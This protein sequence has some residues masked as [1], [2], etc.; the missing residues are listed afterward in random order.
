MSKPIDQDRELFEAH[1]TKRGLPITKA[2]EAYMFGNGRRVAAGEYILEPTAEAWVA[3]QA[4]ASVQPASVAAQEVQRWHIGWGGMESS[5]NGE[6]VNWED[7]AALVTML[8]AA[9]Q[10]V[11]GEQ[12]PVAVVDENDDGQWADI[13]PDV[14]VRVGDMFYAAPPAAQNV[15][16]LVEALQELR[17]LMQ[18]VI[19]GEYAPDSFTLQPA[20]AALAAHRAQQG[21][22]P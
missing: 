1:A 10:P 13:L 12:S 21:E 17:D 19:D 8:A 7:Y 15:D 20:D 3:W 5:P 2:P 9:P 6:Y 14:S 11:S 22:Q 4:R 16:G 18:G